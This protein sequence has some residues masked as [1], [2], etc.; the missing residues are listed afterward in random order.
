MER[1]TGIERDRQRQGRSDS[2]CARHR[3]EDDARHQLSFG[4]RRHQQVDDGPLDLARQERE[5]AIGEGVLHHRHHDQARRDEIGERHVEDAAIAAPQSDVENHQEQHRAD[6][7]TPDRLRLHLEKPAN[8]LNIEAPQ[9]DAVDPG[10]DRLT[11]RRKSGLARIP[12]LHES[13]IGVGCKGG[14]T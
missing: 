8:L 5:T 12:T 9:A 1:G 4:K 3:G 13:G 14:W 2:H 7:R 10:D 11:A 6:R